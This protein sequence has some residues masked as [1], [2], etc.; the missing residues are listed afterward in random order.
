MFS[1]NNDVQRETKFHTLCRVRNAN[2]PCCLIIDGGSCTNVASTMM[3]DKLKLPT[4]KHPRPY[5][6]Q[7]MNDND[8]LK[9]TRQV[10]IAFSI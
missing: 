1:N 5:T 2:L 8:G 3:V 4:I 9:I 10:R 7:W 6:L